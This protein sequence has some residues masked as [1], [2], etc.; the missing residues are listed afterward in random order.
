[1]NQTMLDKRLSALEARQTTTPIHHTAEERA[2]LAQ[3][4]AESL[5]EPAEPDQRQ[6]AYYA[7]RTLKEIASDYDAML[8]GAP[9]PW[10]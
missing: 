1:M 3:R 8:N 2:A 9:A 7:N 6:A 10:E 5:A 4:Y